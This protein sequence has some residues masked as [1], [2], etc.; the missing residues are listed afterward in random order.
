MNAAL[1]EQLDKYGMAHVWT[2][3]DAK[4][5]VEEHVLP[6]EK[7]IEHHLD[8]KLA[9][10]EV[11]I[12][13]GGGVRVPANEVKVIRKKERETVRA[14]KHGGGTLK[15]V[16]KDG[17]ERTIRIKGWISRPETMGSPSWHLE[18][19]IDGDWMVEDM[20]APLSGICGAFGWQEVLTL[21]GRNLN[22]NQVQAVGGAQPTSASPTS[23]VIS[24][25][26]FNG[27]VT[28]TVSVSGFKQLEPEKVVEVC[29]QH[30]INP[31]NGRCPDC[32]KVGL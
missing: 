20:E 27:V 18:A 25:N 11:M 7:T 24:G 16:L 8:G 23:V 1:S 32:G 2:V 31:A 22:V 3:K 14:D 9:F 10:Y 17:T 29:P 21:R 6:G 5:A 30:W 4:G 19:V 12:A 26:T 13:G 15:L 28:P